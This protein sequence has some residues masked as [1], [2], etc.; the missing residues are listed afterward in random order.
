M[1]FAFP[2]KAYWKLHPLIGH[3]ETVKLLH[4]IKEFDFNGSYT[5]PPIESK[6]QR[7]E[8]H[9]TLQEL[10]GNM[11]DTHTETH[12]P[13]KR[14]KKPH[15]IPST[16]SIRVRFQKRLQ[17]STHYP[18]KKRK[19]NNYYT[20]FVLKKTNVEMTQGIV[21]LAKII[22]C[23]P[24]HFSIAGTK[25]KRAITYQR[26]TGKNISMKQLADVNC[27]LY[28][29]GSFEYVDR[30]LSLGD[31]MGNHFRLLVRGV[32]RIGEGDGRSLNDL[33]EGSMSSLK[34]NGFINYFGSQR[35]GQISPKYHNSLI[36]PQ[37]GLALLRDDPEGAVRLLL[38]PIQGEGPT[39]KAK[40]RVII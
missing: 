20:S 35:T 12:P 18:T 34:S 1:M 39:Q 16:P 29:V 31:L 36:F 30:P 37:I 13:P 8:I 11:I 2:D 14:N 26:V 27:P 17:N 40:E 32:A 4:F 6:D 24:N 38:Q 23:R 9:H 10:Y 19:S 3:E 5:L 15:P 28:E 21:D 25:D 22:G 33:I 7:R